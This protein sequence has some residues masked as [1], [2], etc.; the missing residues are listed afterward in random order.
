MKRELWEKLKGEKVEGNARFKGVSGVM[1]L[2]K[3]DK[4]EGN[5]SFPILL[6]SLNYGL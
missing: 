5:S 1:L 6:K 2:E 4:K 3:Y